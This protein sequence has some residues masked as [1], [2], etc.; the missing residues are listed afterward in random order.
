MTLG[1]ELASEHK[2]AE[3]GQFSSSEILY[4]YVFS[5]LCY[6]VRWV[7]ERISQRMR[8]LLSY[9]IFVLETHMVCR[10]LLRC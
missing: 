1:L 9:S 2:L 4:W 8:S 10:L 7:N 5:M 6:E 3:H